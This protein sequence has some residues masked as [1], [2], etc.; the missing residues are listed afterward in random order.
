VTMPHALHRREPYGSPA[1]ASQGLQ[2]IATFIDKNDASIAFKALFLSATNLRGSIERWPAHRAG[3]RAG[4]AFA[5][6]NRDCGAIEPCSLDGTGRQR[7]ERSCREPA[8]R[9]IPT[10]RSPNIVYPATKLK[11]ALS[12][13]KVR[14]WVCVPGGA[15]RTTYSRVAMPSSSETPK[16]HSLQPPQQLQSRTFPARRAG[17]RS[18]DELRAIRD[19]Q[20]VSYPHCS[21]RRLVS[22]N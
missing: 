3:V 17:L 19:F 13:G 12:A 15:L 22:I 21:G 7:A 6:S 1:P 10:R 14:A 11:Q 2:K 9:S 16:R 4:W 8:A 20:M 5:E 18:S